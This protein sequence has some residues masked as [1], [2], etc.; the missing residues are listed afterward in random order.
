[1][2]L[3]RLVLWRHGRTAWNASGRIQGQTDVPLDEVGRAQAQE[4]AARLASL[5]PAF[6]LSS[7]LS[8]AADT[9]RTLAELVGID[10]AHDARLREMAFGIREGLTHEQ[11]FAQH[12]E[13]MASFVA[14]P[15]VVI[16]G[17]ETYAE[18]GE[19]VAGSISAACARLE[20]GQTGML[21]GHGAALRVGICAFLGLPEQ[22]WSRFGG[23]SNCSWAM[24]EERRRGWCITEWNAGSLPEPVLSDEERDTA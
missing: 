20:P 22:I 16:E 23:F 8:R 21:V 24:L 12:P 17:A 9:A 13:A 2:S 15:S 7:D 18:V 4:A 10:V 11:A 3:R 19:R 5:S 14:D 1:V 6:I